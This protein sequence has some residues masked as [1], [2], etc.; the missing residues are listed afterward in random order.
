M[1]NILLFFLLLGM[2]TAATAW[3]R[4]GGGEHYPDL[5]SGPLLPETALEEVLAYPEPIGNVAVS[6]NGRIFFTVHPEARPPGNRLLEFVAGASVPFPNVESQHKL[7][8]TV[9][10]LAV[11][12][13]NRLWTIDHGSHGLGD[14]RLLAFDL[15]TGRVVRDHVFPSEAAPLGSFLQDLAISEDGETI[16][17]ADASIWRKSPAL[18][19]Y[20]VATGRA[21]RVL[22]GS[23]T[24][25][26]EDFVIRTD[27]EP[28]SF[29]G[30][31]A[32]LKGG[33]DGLT[34]HDGWLYFG[35]LT[36]S[37]L[38]RVRLSDLADEDLSPAELEARVEDVARKPLSDGF[39]TDT[40]GRI[41]LTD[42]EHNAISVVGSAGEAQTLLRSR[43]IRWPDALAFGPEGRLYVAD[44]A[45]QQVV[46]KSRGDIAAAGPYRIFRFRPG[47]KAGE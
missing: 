8:G 30:G 34:L 44:S 47:N 16:V 14:V 27:G 12:R 43:R 42:V 23:R 40:G 46:L 39:A 19:V 11:D 13:Q 38:Y 25:A 21:R 10:G 7:F 20:E 31:L 15:E 5:S 36:G 28:F 45:L 33:V 24:V 35:A 22:E 32:N 26:A 4:Y 37:R 41:Y 17:I 3:I 6:G 29:F 1:K 2:G 9:L 18:V